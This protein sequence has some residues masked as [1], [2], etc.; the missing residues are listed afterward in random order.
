[1]TLLQGLHGTFAVVLICTLLFVDEAGL[2]LPIAPN[3]ALLLLTGVLVASGEFS[4][5]VVFPAAFLAMMAGMVA[6]YGWARTVGQ[7]GLL[8]LAGRMNATNVY[9]RAQSHLQSAGPLGI[10]VTRMLPGVR[11]YATLI[12]GAAE[13]DLRT[14]LLGAVP[15]LVVWQIGWCVLGMLVGLPVAHF[16]GHFEKLVVRGIILVAL[17]AVVLFAVREES[18]DRRG[19]LANLTPRLRATLALFTDAGIVASIVGGL[20]LIARLLV[21]VEADGWI[22]ILC[23]SVVLLL[24]LVAGRSI[25]T[26]GETLFDTHYW[27][28]A[29]EP[30]P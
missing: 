17:G 4:I 30:A 27:H 29:N 1:M 20:F 18:P 10:G 16:L 6:G 22:E 5:W 2:P 11:P 25:Q 7:T 14:F 23:A 12:S 8:A 13:V 9:D 19:A 28:R 24:L 3:E 15:A 26:P 21:D